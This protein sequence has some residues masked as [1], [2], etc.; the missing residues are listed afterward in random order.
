MLLWYLRPALAK[1]F[2]QLGTYNT[3]KATLPH[4]RAS[5]GSYIHVSAT[6]HYRGA[7]GPLAT[8]AALVF[9]THDR[10]FSARYTLSGPR[11]RS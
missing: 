9:L 11:L 1:I 10:A 5:K 6:L 8:D 2:G 7:Y 4:L 3:I